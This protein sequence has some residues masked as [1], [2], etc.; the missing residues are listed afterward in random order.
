MKIETIL[1]D[2]DG[3]LIDTND[4]IIASY[5][6]TL[7]HFLP[8]YNTLENIVSFIGEPL[9]KSFKRIN[10][11]YADEMVAMYREYNLAHHDALVKSFDGVYETVQEL[12]RLQYKLGVVTTK[13]RDSVDMGLR[14][15]KLKPFF[16]VVVTFDDVQHPKPDPE[17]L[18]VAMEQLQ[19]VPETTLMIGDSHYDIVAGKNAGT[20]TAGVSWSL[21]GEAYLAAYEPDFMLHHMS[22]LL[23]KIEV[24]VK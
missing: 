8:E 6:H 22:E 5:R 16:P 4:L 21:K 3:T 19:A 7:E 23:Q 17:P 9:H 10:P 2:L 14:L 20:F 12:D 11:N 18:N 13:R 15:T 24:N 1:F